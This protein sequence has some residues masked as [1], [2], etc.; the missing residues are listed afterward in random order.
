MGHCFPPAVSLLSQS[1]DKIVGRILEKRF[2]FARS[3][4]WCASRGSQ[5]SGHFVLN[6]AGSVAAPE[7]PSLL[8]LPSHV[9]HRALSLLGLWIEIDSTGRMVLTSATSESGEERPD[10]CGRRKEN[11]SI[12]VTVM[13][14]RVYRYLRLVRP[15]LRHWRHAVPASLVRWAGIALVFVVEIKLNYR[16]L[17]AAVLRANKSERFKVDRYERFS[18]STVSFVSKTIT[19]DGS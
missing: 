19:W 10:V 7:K 3:S 6:F 2:I 9:E 15:Y 13:A 4:V 17:G 5:H 14:T 1:G 12:D 18:A 16:F 11:Q 8:P